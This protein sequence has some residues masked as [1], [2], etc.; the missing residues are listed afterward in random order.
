MVKKWIFLGFFATGISFAHHGVATLSSV[1][2]EGP[3][4]PLETSSSATLPQDSWLFYLKLDHVKW[5]KYSFYRFPDQK[6]SYDFWM[7]GIGY[8]LKPWLSVYLFVPYY[9]KKALKSINNDPQQGQYSYTNSGFSD[10]SL[11]AV[12]GFKY[13]RGFKLVPQNESL[14][15]LMDWHFTVY[16]GMTIPTGNPNKY[17][18]GRDPKG[19]FEPDMTTGFGKPSFVFGFTSTKQ[20]V[21]FPRI[22]FVF[23]ANYLKFLEHTYNFRED[24]D[25]SRKKYKFGDELRLNVALAYKLYTDLERRFRTDLLLETNF[26]Y[27][28]RDQEDG[29]KLEDSGGKIL[30][31]TVGT[32]LYYKNISTGLGV[33]IPLWKKLNEEGLQQ[34]V[35]G[36]ERYRLIF[37]FSTLF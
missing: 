1:G 3:G 12:L 28:Q 35:E 10:I 21:S 15:D 8:G 5:K 2:L 14:D 29:A 22:T 31:G 26:Q 37:T 6:D 23:D 13:D 16:G 19:E 20:S 27:N 32:R 33:K 17:D 9:V 4:A 18:R 11:M 34:G 24:P 25:G 30:Y 36:K 7:Y